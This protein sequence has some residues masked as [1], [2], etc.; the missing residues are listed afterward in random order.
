MELWDILD[1]N[2]NKTGKTIERGKPMAQDEYHLLV[3]VWIKN[4]NGEFLI[5]KRTPNKTILPNMWETTVGSVIVGEDSLKAAIREVKEETGVELSPIN[6]KFLFRIKRQ[7]HDFADFV[8]I[9]LFNEEVD[10]T[11]VIYQPQ[12]VCGAKWVTTSEIKAM[13]KSGEFADTFTYLEE[14]LGIIFD[15]EEDEKL[16]KYSIDTAI[17]LEK[18]KE[19]EN[20]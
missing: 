13:I 16:Y 4:S 18:E 20:N 7:Q 1:G 3:H 2:G 11:E 8:D 6:G 9:W 10:I 15:E 19:N 14:L 17:K 5:T 12:E